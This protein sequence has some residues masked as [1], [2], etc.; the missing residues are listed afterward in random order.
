MR[1]YLPIRALIVGL[2]IIR[3]TNLR[4]PIR[5]SCISANNLWECRDV[6]TQRTG[7]Q[8]HTNRRG[9]AELFDYA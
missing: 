4:R 5:W 6:W 9:L 3:C 2:L 1:Q 7:P 8:S